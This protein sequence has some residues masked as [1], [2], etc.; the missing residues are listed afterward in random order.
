MSKRSVDKGD[1]GK[2]P[3]AQAKEAR[4][5]DASSASLKQKAKAIDKAG[6]WQNTDLYW[7]AGLILA[8]LFS[9]YLRAIVPWNAVFSGGKVIFSSESDAWYHMMLA[10][11]T[12]INLQRL[13]FDPMTYFPHGT[14]IHFGPFNS[15]TI[16]IF[17]YIFG[18]G[19]PSMHVV[20]V[21]G[22]FLPAVLGALLV[23]PVYFIGRELGG[24][25]CGLISALIVAVLPGQLFNRT[26]LGFT[27]HHA[28]EIFLSTLAMMFFILAMHSGRSMTFEAVQKRASSLKE[29]LLYAALAGVSLGLYI[30]AWSSGF[31]FEGIILLFVILQSAVDHLKGRRVEYLGICSGVTFFVA[32]LMVLPFVQPYY[33][34]NHY[35]YSL[36]QPTILLIGVVAVIMF[37]VLSSFIEEKGFSRYYY[38]GALAAVVVLGTL[39]L[40]LAVPE[41]TST[42]FSGLSIFQART[43]GAATVGEA[44]PLLTYQGEVSWSSML[45]NFPAFGNIVLLSS[46]FLAIIG[47]ALIL[48]RYIRSQRPADLLLLTWSILLLVMTLAQNRFAYYYGVNVALLTGYLAFWLM[49]RGGVSEEGGL[50]DAKEPV[51]FLAS[52]LKV[53]A[54]ALLIFVFLIYP[55]LSTSLVVASYTDGPESDWMTSTAW[56][57]NNTPSPGMDL[58]E[59]Y[60]RPASG[61]YAYPNAA[62]GIMSWWDYGH[63]I[64][65]IGHRIP[66]ANPF[67]QGIGSVTGGVSGSSPFFLAENETRAEKVLVGLD[68]NRSPYLN[69]KYVMID[70]DM[71]TGKFH[72]MAAWSGISVSKY[73][74][75]SLPAAGRATGAG[76]DIS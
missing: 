57:E 54:S 34:F 56:L 38:P 10:K 32:T 3:S 43:G 72:A 41:F 61:Q 62:Y 53:I 28:A 33:G 64:E 7:Y 73:I 12:V 51:K 23:F 27:D 44:A 8:A 46:F 63:L 16:A 65:T 49:Q 75:A 17:S 70:L 24:K 66:N 55:A 5:L 50:F 74:A 52:N 42:L 45:A 76:S 6:I 35:L 68:L 69:T 2:T 58:Y 59:K 11:G 40:A 14:P 4:P 67:Q 60:V 47:M 29:P 48:M 37:S 19:H 13:W 22:A 20:E 15:W 31:L 26:V 21:V 1:G 18:L 39:I 71:A 36:F 25:S 30:D 9:F